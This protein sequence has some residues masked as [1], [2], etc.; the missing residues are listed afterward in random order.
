MYALVGHTFPQFGDPDDLPC[1]E[2]DKLVT[3]GARLESW[4]R[5]DDDTV[6]AML[7]RKML[8]A[9]RR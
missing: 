9:I 1:A 6:E 4:R 2:F 5:G 8:Q 7:D 3:R